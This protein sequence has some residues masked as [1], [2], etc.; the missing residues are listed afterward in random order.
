MLRKGPVCNHLFQ[1]SMKHVEK[2]P[3]VSYHLAGIPFG[4]KEY[5]K[6]VTRQVA[7]SCPKGIS[8]SP[9]FEAEKKHQVMYNPQDPSNGAYLPTVW[10]K[11]IVPKDPEPSL[12]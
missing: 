12:E 4:R 10:L 5:T 1:G 3:R 6:H 7:S 2:P 11:C 9:Q 8:K